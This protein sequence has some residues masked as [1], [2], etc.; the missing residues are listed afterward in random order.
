MQGGSA[1]EKKKREVAVLV[2]THYPAS[3]KTQPS[4]KSDGNQ[5]NRIKSYIYNSLYGVYMVD[6]M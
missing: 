2:P 1:Q 6:M 5:G 4:L 3:T